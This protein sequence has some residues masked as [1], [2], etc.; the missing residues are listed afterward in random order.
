MKSLSCVWLFATPWTITYQAPLSMNFPG[1]N[2]GVGCHFLLQRIFPTQGSNPGLPHCRQTLYHLSYRALSPWTLRMFSSVQFNSVTQSSPTLC[3]P[4]TVALQASL[5]ITNS[6]SSPKFLFHQVGDAIQ[7][8]HPLSSPS[9]LAP[10]PSQHQS[11]FQWVNTLHEVAKVLEF[12][13]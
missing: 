10:N 3:D 4:I 11:L 12:Q 7:P 1:R 5:S 2:T 6:R 13:L 9:P 8:S